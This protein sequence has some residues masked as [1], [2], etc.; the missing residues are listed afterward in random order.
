M[1]TNKKTNLTTSVF[2]IFLIW[3]SGSITGGG[4]SSRQ[5]LSGGRMRKLLGAG[6]V[7]W[8]NW[9]IRLFVDCHCMPHDVAGPLGVLVV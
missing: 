3:F 6:H 5:G 1:Q 8:R 7:R 9:H 2:F 4:S